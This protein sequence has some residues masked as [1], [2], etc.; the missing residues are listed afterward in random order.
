MEV[1]FVSIGDVI[2]CDLEDEVIVEL[3]W[4]GNID[5]LEYLIYKYKNFVCVKL[6]FYFL[7]GVDWEDIV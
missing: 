3:V 5:V 6:R 1:G 7:V 2:F 4:K